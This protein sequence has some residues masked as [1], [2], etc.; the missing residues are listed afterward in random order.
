M[1]DAGLQLGILG[2]G[3][4]D[5]FYAL[6]PDRAGCDVHFL[7]R[8]EYALAIESGLKLNGS[9]PSHPSAAAGQGLRW[10]VHC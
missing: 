7:L 6:M 5:G 9:E 4:M 8:S 1:Q 2:T 3:S 10:R